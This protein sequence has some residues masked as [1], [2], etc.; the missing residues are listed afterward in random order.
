MEEVGAVESA[1]GDEVA[2]EVEEHGHVAAFVRA[3]GEEVWV[4]RE[5]G[6]GQEDDSDEAS[7]AGDYAGEPVVPHPAISLSE[8]AT[9]CNRISL[10]M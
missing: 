7:Y 6:F 5:E 8:E 9:A 1:T 2:F 4:T 3:V 10:Q